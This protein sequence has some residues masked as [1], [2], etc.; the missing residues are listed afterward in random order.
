MAW[1]Q[2]RT[3]P[4]SKPMLTQFSDAGAYMHLEAESCES[5]MADD[6]SLVVL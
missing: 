2:S 3:K 1:H 6:I 4:L 5:I